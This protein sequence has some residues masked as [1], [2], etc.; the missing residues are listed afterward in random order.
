MA[1][2]SSLAQSKYSGKSSDVMA[3][4]I[5]ARCPVLAGW[6]RGVNVMVSP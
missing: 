4:P 5:M 1:R 6:L 3:I 2:P